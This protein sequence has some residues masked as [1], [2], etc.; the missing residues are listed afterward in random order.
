MRELRRL[1]LGHLHEKCVLVH[2]YV[3][4]LQNP[5]N[6]IQHMIM[7]R[8][9]KIQGTTRKLGGMEKC[10]DDNEQR[11]CQEQCYAGIVHMTLR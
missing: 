6:R 7:S 11:T 5:L 3:D 2:V 8:A 9:S 10:G 4:T 1:H